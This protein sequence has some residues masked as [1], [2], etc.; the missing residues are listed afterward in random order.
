MFFEVCG[1]WKTKKDNGDMV[2]Q[3]TFPVDVTI[4]AGTKMVLFAKYTPP[5][6]RKENSPKY[7]VSMTASE[8]GSSG[9]NDNTPPNY[10]DPL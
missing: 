8:A 10:D 6:E 7:R 9:A 3:F 2:G 1:L 4:K 5:S